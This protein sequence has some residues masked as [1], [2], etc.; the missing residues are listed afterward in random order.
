[1]SCV[2]RK[3]FLITVSEYSHDMEYVLGAMVFHG[4]LEVP[5]C[6]KANLLD[7]WVLEFSCDQ[8]SL[9]LEAAP[10]PTEC[11]NLVNLRV[12]EH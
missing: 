10:H 3:V 11:P 7:A 12:T 4:R 2:Y 6:P 9:S 1:M 5:E 8:F